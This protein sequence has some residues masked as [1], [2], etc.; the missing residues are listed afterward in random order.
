MR[1]GRLDERQNQNQLNQI[2]EN[3]WLSVGTMTSVINVRAYDWQIPNVKLF[4]QG[5]IKYLFTNYLKAINW[6]AAWY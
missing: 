3:Y 1:M 2:E 6:L 5:Y 4:W